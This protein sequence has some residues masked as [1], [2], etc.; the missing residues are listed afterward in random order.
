[1]IQSL[2]SHSHLKLAKFC[3]YCNLLLIGIKL[4]YKSRLKNWEKEEAEKLI[5]SGNVT[6]KVITYNIT[7]EISDIYICWTH[8]H[9]FKGPFWYKCFG[10]GGWIVDLFKTT[11][12]S[13]G[14]TCLLNSCPIV[15]E[16]FHNCR[17]IVSSGQVNECFHR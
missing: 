15:Y 12:S 2:L 13:S 14:C 7:Y 10:N 11:R 1:M 16:T 5:Q 3:T 4:T 8:V 17:L 9:L 6:K